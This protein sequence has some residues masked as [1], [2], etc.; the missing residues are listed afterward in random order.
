MALP[1]APTELTRRL[2]AAA[3]V[4]G[5]IML[6]VQFVELI[7]G[8]FPMLIH[9]AAWRLSFAGGAANIMMISLLAT[10]IMIATAVIFNDAGVC[11]TFGIL[12]ALAA[13]FYVV[14]SGV[15]ALDALQMRGQVRMSVARQYD[16]G[17]A[18]VI[19]RML[20]AII[21]YIVL[22]VTALRSARAMPKEVLR[23][24][25]A[26]GLLVANAL[27]PLRADE[28]TSAKRG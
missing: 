14:M 5:S 6:V 22:S 13:A 16:Y 25:P 11:L 7:F 15:F 10:F 28:P 18:W 1:L 9:S 12:A 4:L 8:V 24:R 2:R 17:S 27:P 3:Y 20:M 19:A 23:P 21:G 26:G